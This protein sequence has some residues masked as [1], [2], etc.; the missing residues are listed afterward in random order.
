MSGDQTSGHRVICIKD[1]P[2]L[3]FKGKDKINMYVEILNPEDRIFHTIYLNYQEFATREIYSQM[4]NLES[5]LIWIIITDI[6]HDSYQFQN[7]PRNSNQY[8]I[9][10]VIYT[11]PKI[12]YDLTLSWLKSYISYFTYIK[13]SVSTEL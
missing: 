2:S 13:Q 8:L 7:H 11:S 4:L 1:M 12:N 6:Y 10:I 9:K 3:R 5:F